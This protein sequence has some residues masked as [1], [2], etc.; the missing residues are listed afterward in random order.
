MP[1]PRLQ[2]LPPS[3]LYIPD[4]LFWRLLPT[5]LREHSLAYRTNT[6]NLFLVP[7]ERK[8]LRHSVVSH[9]CPACGHP[10]R[11]QVPRCCRGNTSLRAAGWAVLGGQCQLSRERGLSAGLTSMQILL[12]FAISVVQAQAAELSLLRLL[13]KAQLLSILLASSPPQGLSPSCLKEREGFKLHG[14]QLLAD[15]R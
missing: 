4:R 8:A 6:S 14:Q 2:L 9:W 3:C 10:S 5:S 1:F 7:C 12:L 15:G 13:N 11:H